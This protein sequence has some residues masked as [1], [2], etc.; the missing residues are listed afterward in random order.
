MNDPNSK[1]TPQV[2]LDQAGDLAG[3]QVSRRNLRYNLDEGLQPDE[4]QVPQPPEL[5]Q[6]SDGSLEMPLDPR[7]RGSGRK[8][9]SV[10]LRSHEDLKPALERGKRNRLP[11]DMDEQLF[12]QNCFPSIEK[13]RQNAVTHIEIKSKKSHARE[14]SVESQPPP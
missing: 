5:T 7:K 1:T 11:Q 8:R 13:P 6:K 4:F 2:L 3:I 10:V 14:P 12:I 9:V